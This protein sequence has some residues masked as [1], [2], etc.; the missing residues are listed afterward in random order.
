MP[1]RFFNALTREKEEF[2][3]IDDMKVGLYTCGPTVYDY[4]HIGN[5]RTYLFEDIL[6]RY[7]EYSGYDVKQV[8]NLTDVDD[9]TIRGSNEKGIT[10]NEY[11]APF[12][13]GFYQDR[14]TLNVEPAHVYPRATEHVPQMM[15]LIKILLE[16]GYAY[17]AE[18][19][20]IYFDISKFPGYGKLSH[21]RIEE[22]RAGARVS[23]DEYEK[24]QVSDFALWKAW[25][26]A[27]GSV[28]WETE[29][30]KGRPGWSIEC[31]A[32]S[33][34]YLGETFDMHTGGVDNIFPH[35]E[36]EIAQ[37]EGATGKKFVN[38]WLHSEHLQVDGRK[39]AKSLGNFYT[40]RDVIARGYDPLAFRYLVLGAHYKSKLNFTWHAMDSAKATLDNLYEFMGRL[41]RET[42]TGLGDAVN[43]AK[44]A[45][46]E[47]M[48][49]DLNTPVALAAIFGLVKE[50]NVHGKG[51]R[52]VFEAMVD[53][54]RVLG[55]KLRSTFIEKLTV[56][57]PVEVTVLVEERE[58]ARKAKDWGASDRIRNEVLTMGYV[59]EDTPQGAR[60]KKQ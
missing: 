8:M 15:A 44:Q 41:D 21:F 48:D 13:E 60:I 43:R 9:K 1:I 32:M 16:K 14:D 33:M 12:I 59:I 22:L 6:R 56:E 50:V 10:L 31:S 42:P 58:R 35:H 2:H 47:A 38:Y 45:F 4:A 36:N 40:L 28:F 19:K 26:E 54:D 37:S 18:D 51:G 20:C 55:L 17:K 11:T 3:A 30:G 49:D 34:Q 7:L 57:A 27:D 5:W 46:V 23:S 53:F 25:D 29:L 24:A 52:E 39:M